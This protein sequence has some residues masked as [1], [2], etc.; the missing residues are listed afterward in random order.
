M[1]DEEMGFHTYID[2]LKFYGIKNAQ[3]N[4]RE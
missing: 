4:K 1:F 2:F 3:G